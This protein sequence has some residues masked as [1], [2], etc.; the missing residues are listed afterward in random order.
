[1]LSI[2]TIPEALAEL[3]KQTGRVWTD[4]EFFD[5][6]TARSVVLHAASP[7]TARV[8]IEK[9][10]DDH[11]GKLVKCPTKPAPSTL[12][13]VLFPGQVGQLWISG[14]TTTNHPANT[15]EVEDEVRIF[16]EPVHVTRQQV[17]VKADSL[18]KIVDAWR[19]AQAGR[20]IKDP[21]QPGGMKWQ[22]GPD[23]MF[24]IAAQLLTQSSST[25]L[26]GP[27]QRSAAQDAVIIQAIAKNGFD[28]LH[29]PK[30]PSGKPGVKK[31]MR[32]AV[33]NNQLFVGK[34][35]F[36]KTWERLASR[37]DIV[38]ED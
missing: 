23:W 14:E 11:E 3:E 13:A 7:L 34:T 8:I 5:V 22:R 24:P 15:Y 12:L 30:P 6:A 9:W 32:D 19:N 33:S 37:G 21:K 28:P 38:F 2:S 35:V 17:R 16:T 26:A 18:K 4:S 36:D 25:A 29:L 27:Q 20:W 31:A 1:M 10:V